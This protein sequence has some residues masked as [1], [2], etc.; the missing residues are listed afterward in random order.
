[1]CLPERTRLPGAS[2]PLVAGLVGLSLGGRLDRGGSGRC[3]R[4][5]RNEPIG[6]GADRRGRR[7]FS[8]NWPPR[9]QPPIKAKSDQPWQ[10]CPLNIFNISF[11]LGATATITP[12]P[13]SASNLDVGMTVFHRPAPC[14]VSCSAGA[15]GGYDRWEG[16]LRPD[17]LCRLYRLPD[18]RPVTVCTRIPMRIR[19]LNSTRYP[20]H[21][22]QS[23]DTWFLNFYYRFYCA[24]FDALS[25]CRGSRL[26]SIEAGA[27]V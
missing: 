2:M 5:L 12:L 4:S 10:C 26:A 14:S 24:H 7:D 6:G 27:A 21:K 9:P 17:D 25:S 1:M 18:R 23:F 13:L 19:K 3:G 22:N 8:R 11:V 15:E 20:T 16:V